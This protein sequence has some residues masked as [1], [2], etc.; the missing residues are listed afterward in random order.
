MHLESRV[1]IGL[2]IMG[3]E[4]LYHVPPIFEF[5]WAFLFLFKSFFLNVWAFLTKQLFHSLQCWI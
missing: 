5:F 1:F 4:P 3:C 2:A